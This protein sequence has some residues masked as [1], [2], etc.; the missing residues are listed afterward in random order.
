MGFRQRSWALW[1]GEEES[2]ILYLFLIPNVGVQSLYNWA[3]EWKYR[4]VDVGWIC[5]CAVCTDTKSGVGV[6]KS[7][8]GELTDSTNRAEAFSL[9]P[10]VWAFGVTF[11]YVEPTIWSY[12]QALTA[13][14]PNQSFPWWN[15]I[16]PPR[17]LP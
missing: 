10:V 9:M 1:L 15:S 5:V 12:S 3:S 8:M 4:C 16:S 11:G 14:D 17:A 2:T 7:V 13:H 6:M